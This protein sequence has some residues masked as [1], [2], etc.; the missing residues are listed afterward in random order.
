M[1]RKM[2]EE[3]VGLPGMSQRSISRRQR[4]TVADFEQ[5]R[6]PSSSNLPQTGKI[7]VAA[8]KHVWTDGGTILQGLGLCRFKRHSARRAAQANRAGCSPTSPVIQNRHGDKSGFGRKRQSASDGM[9]V[10][11]WRKN[12]LLAGL[13]LVG[14]G[15]FHQSVFPPLSRPDRPRIIVDPDSIAAVVAEANAAI[16]ADWAAHGLN[17]A[18]P[19]SELTI[20][21]RL[22]LALTGATPSLEEIR[23][24]ERLPEGSRVDD[25]LSRL[26]ADRRTADYV[27]E[28]LARA[29]VGVEDGPFLL[30]RRRRFVSWLADQLLENQ[31]YDEIVRRLV[32]AS[33]IWTDQPAT[34]F[35]TIA[36]KPDSD[37][38]PDPNRLAARTARAFLGARIDCAECHDHPFDRWTQKDFQRL[39][40]YYAAT[41]RSLRGIFD[42]PGDYMAEDKRTG[43]REAV[44]PRV[45]FQPELCSPEAT[46]RWEL[47]LW[48]TNPQNRAFSRAAVNRAWAI[49]FG[50]PLV[51]PI[52]SIPFDDNVP[53]PLDVLARDF[54]EHG[55]DWRRLLRVI[56]ALRPM[57]IDSRSSSE[58]TDDISELH[59]QHWA[60]FPIT[61]LRPEQVVGALCQASSLSTLDYDSHIVIRTIKFFAQSEFISHYGDGGADEFDSRG[62]T[63]PQRLLMMNGQLV[64]A[65]TS[66]N[67]FANA[68]TRIARLSPT[69]ERAIETAALAVLTRRPS[70]DEAAALA[71]QYQ[72]AASDVDGLED[73]Y[74]ALL[75]CTEF[76]WNH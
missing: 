37:D 19:A 43:Q 21:R 60:S 65:K 10:A 75:N 20:A 70:A 52:D 24:L 4:V 45:P 49:L 33:G 48:L 76:S 16:E 55:F 38:P 1:P 7:R 6:S 9:S 40:A 27:A 61:R 68:V 50:R 56:A 64:R 36:I 25:H 17:P 74:W 13:C 5:S 35:I 44:S 14:A 69:P 41:Q 22:S 23:D 39:A 66:D 67:I 26:L 57:R 15:V 47:A 42:T 30:F 72:T 54:S 73:V 28:R 62:G 29:Y 3:T 32:T 51:S 63:I 53:P 2:G 59:E 8:T 31:P 58:A 18:P 46:G 71:M 11:M 12:L 34:N